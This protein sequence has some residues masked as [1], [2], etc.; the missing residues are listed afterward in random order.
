[1][2]TVDAEV[3]K[4]VVEGIV[5]EKLTVAGGHRPVLQV[6]KFGAHT[7][8]QGLPRE[9]L[10]LSDGERWVH[11]MA[12][13]QEGRVLTPGCFVRLVKYFWQGVLSLCTAVQ[14]FGCPDDWTSDVRTSGRPGP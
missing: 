9:K 13:P 2:A 1:M 8:A 11:G 7:N 3:D 12:V 14:A 5:N 6:V 10:W 4:D